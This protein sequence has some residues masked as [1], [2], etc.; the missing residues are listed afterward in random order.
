VLKYVYMD[1]IIHLAYNKLSR[2]LRCV[3]E[4]IDMSYECYPK[5]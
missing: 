3:I 2:R 4:N 5:R 1:I